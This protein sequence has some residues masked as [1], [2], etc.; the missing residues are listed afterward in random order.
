MDLFLFGL[1]HK[2]FDFNIQYAIVLSFQCCRS[3]RRSGHDP[4]SRERDFTDGR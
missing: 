1:D 3:S 4:R 2:M